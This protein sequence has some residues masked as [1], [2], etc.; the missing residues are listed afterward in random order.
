MHV[1][2]AAAL[3]FSQPMPPKHAHAP[4][5]FEEGLPK[6]L[7]IVCSG[8]AI[9]N[10]QRQGEAVATEFPFV[11]RIEKSSISASAG[12]SPPLHRITL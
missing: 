2:D 9:P 6:K 5:P 4:K 3:P 1:R 11:N 8:R 7:P 10:G 12:I